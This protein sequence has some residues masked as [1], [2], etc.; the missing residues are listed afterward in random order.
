M[1]ILDTLGGPFAG[2]TSSDSGGESSSLPA[3]SLVGTGVGALFGGPMGAAAGNLFGNVL[4]NIGSAKQAREQMDFQ[5][6]MSN[7]SWQR[8]VADLKAAGLNPALAYMKGGA[9]TPSGAMAP[10][11]N[12][13]GAA[14][15]SGLQAAQTLASLKNVAA[16]T[17]LKG[18][19]AAQVESE[20]S[21]N[22]LRDPLIRAQTRGAVSSS[23][24]AEALADQALAN[25]ENIQVDTQLKRGTLE[26]GISRA[27]SEAERVAAEARL[28]ALGIPRAEN[29]AAAES[30]WWMKKV[31]PYLEG[32]SRA[33][34]SARDAAI[35][36]G[37]IP[38]GI[39]Q[40]W[41]FAKK[42]FGSG[43]STYGLGQ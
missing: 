25:L 42:R 22:V 23:R 40:L 32:V 9:S 30:S 13:V 14:V 11:V 21:L 31:D 12:E 2:L 37:S 19:Q 1:G 10:V 5:E 39:G 43:L 28:S 8:G 3:V 16:D 7:T 4:Q 34:S 6:R 33:A 41:E 29:R 35:G 26:S 17:E 15:S 38:G 27:K 36:L 20:T 18:S 24:Q